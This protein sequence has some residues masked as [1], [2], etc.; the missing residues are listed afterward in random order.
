M[1]Q[2]MDITVP[3]NDGDPYEIYQ[4]EHLLIGDC[5]IQV[6]EY[7]TVSLYHSGHEDSRVYLVY[8]T[9]VGYSH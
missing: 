8:V 3:S 4:K 7:L 6:T 1:R 5:S 2:S 9:I